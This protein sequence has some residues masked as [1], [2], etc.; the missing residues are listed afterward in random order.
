MFKKFLASAAIVAAMSTSAF[1]ADPQPVQVE[2]T[3][4]DGTVSVVSFM[5]DGT[6]TSSSGA[7]GTYKNDA[8]TNTLCIT[9]AGAEEL[10]GT[11]DKAVSKAGDTAV[12][13]G[14]SGSVTAKLLS[15][16][17]APQ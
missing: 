9:P 7:T 6:Y 12:L 1:A 13:T 4:A 2:F 17:P 5:A 8:A 14:P 16:I 10:C 15:D 3:Q 11:A